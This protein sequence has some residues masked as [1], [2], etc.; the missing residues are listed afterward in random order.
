MKRIVALLLLAALFL[1]IP[2]ALGEVGQPSVVCTD[3]PCY[4]F[5]RAVIGDSANIT[6][7]I[8]P[9]AE[10]HSY[11]PSPSDIRA[12]AECDLFIYIGG[13][14]DAWV[15]D[16][17]SSFGTAAPQTLRLIDCVH[18]LEEETQEGMTVH[19]HADNETETEYDEHIWTSPVNAGIMVGAICETLCAVSPENRESY[20]GN[21]DSYK[22]EIA[23]VDTEFREIADNAARHEMIF[24]DRFPFLYFVREYGIDYYAAFPSCSAESEPSAKTMAY[25]IDKIKDDDIPV[26]YTIEMSNQRT[27]KVIAEE[28]G[29]K[30][31]TFYSIQNVSAADFAAGETY[32]SLMRKNVEALREGLN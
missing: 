28:T 31:R 10:V 15:D 24:A 26:I 30:I 1:S 27:A 29:A 32:V 13:E 6:L 18:T 17:L 8:R 22:D 3:F 21:A 25:L 14:S 7:L 23:A 20:I 12:I 5:A 11:E 4:D 2:C 16:I 9:G 19:E